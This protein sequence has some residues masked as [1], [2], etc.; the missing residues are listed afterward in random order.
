MFWPI[1]LPIQ[2][3]FL[4]LVGMVTFFT[5]YAPKFKWS[6]GNTFLI[7]TLLACVA[8]IP[9]VMVILPI[10]NSFRFGLFHY[11]EYSDAYFSH[12]KSFRPPKARQITVDQ[13]H[14]GHRAKYLISEKDLMDF[15]DDLWDKYGERSARSR[16]YMHS[17][18]I[19]YED[20]DDLFGDLGWPVLE[21]A[22]ELHSPVKSNRAGADYFYDRETGT[23]YHDAGYW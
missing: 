5:V 6:R 22:I 4:I 16:D 2:I 10:V 9:S 19:V 20:Q 1:V 17:D 23:A 11:E 21:N 18:S 12:I 15:L 3:A 14:G 13:R 8:F 7:T